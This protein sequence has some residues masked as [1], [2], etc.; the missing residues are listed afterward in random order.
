M[1][2]RYEPNRIYMEDENGKLLAEI[3]YAAMRDG[4]VNIDHTYVSPKLRNQGIADKLMRAVCEVLAKD[5]KTAFAT[6]P[7]AVAWF[8]KHPEEAKKLRK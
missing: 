5:S 6:C 3:T 4:S 7:Y 1:E 8:E 2:F